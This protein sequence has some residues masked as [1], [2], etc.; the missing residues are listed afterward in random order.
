MLNTANT[1]IITVHR[2]FAPEKYLMQQIFSQ[3]RKD[4]QNTS[5][6]SSATKVYR[7][8]S[9][10]IDVQH[11]KDKKNYQDIWHRKNIDKAHQIKEGYCAKWN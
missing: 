6:L 8:S 5:N 4:I 11:R 1:S 10:R 3:Y 9:K 7:I 2:F